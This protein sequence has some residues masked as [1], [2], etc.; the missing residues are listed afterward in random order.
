MNSKTEAVELGLDAFDL[1]RPRT[2]R[3]LSE[4]LKQLDIQPNSTQSIWRM[5]RMGHLPASGIGRKK[6]TLAAFL[7]VTM[8][9]AK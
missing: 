6:T 2:A 8:P 9:G 7:A 3:Q 1:Q 5:M 4:R